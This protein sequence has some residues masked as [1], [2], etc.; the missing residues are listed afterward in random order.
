MLTRTADLARDTEGMAIFEDSDRTWV[1]VPESHGLHLFDDSTAG[2]YR[3]LNTT[4]SWYLQFA[5]ANNMAKRKQVTFKVLAAS[6]WKK[7]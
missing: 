2:V 7:L 1:E 6:Y 4:K 5:T 3:V